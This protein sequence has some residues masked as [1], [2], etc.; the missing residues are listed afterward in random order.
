MKL[1][2]DDPDDVISDT[3]NGGTCKP[4]QSRQ[5]QTCKGNTYVAVKGFTL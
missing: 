1:L 5:G 3:F 4:T 2:G